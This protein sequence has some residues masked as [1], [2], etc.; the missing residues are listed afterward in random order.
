MTDEPAKKRTRKPLTDEQKL[1][2]KEHVRAWR[3]ANPNHPRAPRSEAEKARAR[4][5]AK[6]WY[7]IPEN[8]EKMKARNREWAK[9]NREKIAEY[10]RAWRARNPTK[11]RLA[12][13]KSKYKL[14]S[15]QAQQILD[16]HGVCECCGEERATDIDH[17]HATGEFRGFICGG[18]NT[19]AGHIKD[20][21]AR[22]M[23][24]ARY[25]LRAQAARDNS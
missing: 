3:Q 5:R 10:A 23:A 21:P 1:R 13:M 20:S 9:A 7:Q 4:E 12:W 25:L 8:A 2:Q 6:E 22:A 14:T 18:C 11:R 19:A 24:L 15:E 17:D 16:H